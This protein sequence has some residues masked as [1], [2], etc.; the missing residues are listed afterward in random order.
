MCTSTVNASWRTCPALVGGVE[1]D[2]TREQFRNGEVLGE[3]MARQRPPA[4]ILANP[5]HSRHH[6]DEQYLLLTARVR[7]RL[8]L[9]S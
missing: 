4:A 1:V 8:A 2:L 7:T 5:A 9:T 3:P 6:R